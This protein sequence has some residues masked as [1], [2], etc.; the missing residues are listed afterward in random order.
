MFMKYILK[1]LQEVNFIFKIHKMR[2][3][4]IIMQF[5]KHKKLY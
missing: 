4:D 5:N 1:K 3:S 2:L